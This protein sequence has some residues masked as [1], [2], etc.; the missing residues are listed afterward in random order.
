MYHPRLNK[1]DTNFLPIYGPQ[2]IKFNHLLE[3]KCCKVT[4]DSKHH[5]K[6]GRIQE[7][8]MDIF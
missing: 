8:G 5:G 1:L 7:C 6:Y 3:F 2:V 4:A